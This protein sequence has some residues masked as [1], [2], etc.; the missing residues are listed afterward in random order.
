MEWIK[1]YWPIV[2][3]FAGWIITLVTD[4][5]ELKR[6]RAKV[7]E[8]DE[9]FDAREIVSMKES[10]LSLERKYDSLSEEV[11]SIR[12]LLSEISTKVGLLI[13]GKININ[14]GDE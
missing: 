14:N 10:F 3:T 1:E 2:I 7:D 13:D 4:H 6:L 12:T 8:L 11:R 5:K 9:T